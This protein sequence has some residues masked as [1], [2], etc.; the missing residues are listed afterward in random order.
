VIRKLHYRHP[1]FTLGT[2]RAQ[3][4]WPEVSGVRRTHYCGAYWRY[5]FH[6]DGLVSATRVAASLGVRW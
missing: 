2:V 1:R 4:R 5:G 3:R 6:E